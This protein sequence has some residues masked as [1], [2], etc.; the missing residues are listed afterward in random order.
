MR[1]P[2]RADTPSHGENSLGIGLEFVGDQRRRRAL[3]ALPGRPLQLPIQQVVEI[4][5]Y[6]RRRIE[7]S[8]LC[9]GDRVGSVA[10]ARETVIEPL[11]AD[12]VRP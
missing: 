3:R 2:S 11:L 7:R 10:S 12:K 4:C 6:A 5:I 1:T 8:Y 9:S